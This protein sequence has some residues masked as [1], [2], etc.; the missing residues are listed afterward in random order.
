MTKTKV[1]VLYGG[2]SAEHEVS[3]RSAAFVLRNLDRNKY[4]ISAVAIDKAGR[5]LPQDTAKLLADVPQTIPITQKTQ[6]AETETLQEKSTVV[7]PVL[8]GTFGEDGTMQGLLDLGEVAYIG[9]DTL[10]S[11]IGMDKVVSKKLAQ[12]AGVPIVPFRDLR[13]QD[14]VQ[15]KDAFIKECIKELGFPMF[16]KPA[17]LGSSVGITK[18]KTNAADLE[19]ACLEA[20]KF[21]EKLLVEKSINA[22][23]L[24]CAALG[25]YN[26][27][28]SVVGEIVIRNAEF[29]DYEAKYQTEDGAEIVIP[30]NLSEA[31][32]KE[33]QDISRRVFRALELYGMA[34]I[35]LFLD[36]DTGEFYFN[37]VNTIPGFT[38][39]SQYP[40]LWKASG[41]SSAELLDELVA[42]AVRR[43][44]SR[45][46]LQ[47]SK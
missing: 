32:V 40:M 44:D 12:I 15:Q 3:C 2:R 4:D 34:R 47:R 6:V 9:P 10:G 28:L 21:D 19:K 5:W 45:L 14:W 25:D 18:V 17:R 38:A 13:R 37:E 41:L 1:M 26:P 43:R 29:Y 16:V 20:F 8:H 7:F 30:A 36:K 33:V 11:A 35:D 23:E 24:E 46:A 42:L 31:Q 22:R 39:I 27:K